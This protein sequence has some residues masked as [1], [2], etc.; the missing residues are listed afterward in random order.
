MKDTEP[1]HAPGVG[2]RQRP[3]SIA[4]PL[5]RVTLG[6]VELALLDVGAGTPVVCIHGWP[7][8][9][10]C[11]RRLAACLV[12]GHRVVAPDLRGFGDSPVVE[13][14]FDKKTLAADVAHLIDHLGLGACV[15]VGHD[16]GGPIAYRLTLDRPD[17]V[18][19][20]VIINGR[21][22]L[23]ARHTELMYTP[24][25]SAERWYFHFNRIPGLPE[26]MIGASLREFL[27]YL[28]DH[29]SAGARVF[30]EADLDELVRVYGREQ[31]LRAG[32]GLYR[33]ALAEDVEHWNEHAGAVIEQPS[34]V[35]WGAQDP[36]LPP[37]YIEGVDSVT[38]DLEVRIRHDA[39]HFLAEQASEWCAAHIADFIQRRVAP[40]ASRHVPPRAGS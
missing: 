21:M 34:L 36:V 15:I 37:E 12:P 33:T 25:H 5:R 16:W 38:P 29:W 40:G 3:D 19:G 14:G 32:L 10:Y 26:R 28:L 9:S 2:A 1:E 4:D 17:L 18:S 23:L 8:H 35:L 11:W 39:G 20:L 7:Q 13:G 22:P 24:A 31:G 30:S 6:D 27:S